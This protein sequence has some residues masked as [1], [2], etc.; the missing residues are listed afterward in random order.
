MSGTFAGQ[1]GQAAAPHIHQV[2]FEGRSVCRV[3]TAFGLLDRQWELRHRFEYKWGWGFRPRLTFDAYAG[4][5]WSTPGR[6]RAAA[7]RTWMRRQGPASR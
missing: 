5:G 2:A 6:G 3:L 1:A 4:P 7:T